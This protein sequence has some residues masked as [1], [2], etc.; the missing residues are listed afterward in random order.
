MTRVRYTQLE[1]NVLPQYFMDLRSVSQ[2]EISWA[3]RG[4]DI[5]LA[6]KIKKN[7]K[8]F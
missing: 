6:K 4:Y 8:R 3:K 7:S 2:K 5:A 1:S